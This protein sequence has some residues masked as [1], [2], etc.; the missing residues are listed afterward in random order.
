MYHCVSTNYE[1]KCILSLF[2][3]F[4]CKNFMLC[5]LPGKPTHVQLYNYH[6]CEFFFFIMK[7]I[8]VLSQYKLEAISPLLCFL[9]FLL[10]EFYA[11]H[12]FVARAKLSM[13]VQWKEP[14]LHV[15]N[16]EV[17]IFSILPVGVVLC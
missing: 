12:T 2:F 17:S 7:P 16:T 9:L 15:R 5:I 8:V 11:R 10:E 3:L 1:G 4:N 13:P 6:D 14:P